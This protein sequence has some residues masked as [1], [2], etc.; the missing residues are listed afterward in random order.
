ME[1]Q[2]RYVR[3]PISQPVRFKIA[4]TEEEGDCI[5][6]DLGPRGVGLELS[7]EILS[8]SPLRLDIDL[9]EQGVLTATADIM[10][11]KRIDDKIVVGLQFIHIPDANREKIFKY[12]FS[13]FR[14]LILKSWWDGLVPTVSPAME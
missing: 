3:W 14:G 12:M 6:R 10:W 13:N 8:E 2:R 5:C 7:E 11:Q 9:H 1:E 4:E